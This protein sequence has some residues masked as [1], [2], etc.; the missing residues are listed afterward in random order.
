[1]NSAGHK[2]INQT[3]VKNELSATMHSQEGRAVTVTYC[4]FVLHIFCATEVID[5]LVKKI[6]KL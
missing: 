4:D 6:I 2:N 1:M 5:L 3:I